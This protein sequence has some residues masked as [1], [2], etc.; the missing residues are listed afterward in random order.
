MKFSSYITSYITRG[1]CR[2]KSLLA[3]V[4]CVRR[5]IPGPEPASAGGAVIGDV[6]G[7]FGEQITHDLVDG[8]V[9]FFVQGIE[10][11]P[12]YLPHIVFLFGDLEFLGFHI[13]HGLSL[14]N[15]RNIELLYPNLWI[16]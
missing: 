12:E 13:R 11:T 7:V 15:D 10:H 16:L 8:V 6:G 14:L 4:I 1:F 3:G 2:S 9:T 5:G